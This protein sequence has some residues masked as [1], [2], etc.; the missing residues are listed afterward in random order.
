MAAETAL[1]AT[2]FRLGSELGYLGGIIQAAVISIINVGVAILC[3]LFGAPQINHVHYARKMIGGLS[4]L[5]WITVAVVLNVFAAHYRS[6]LEQD[7]F[8][9]VTAAVDS[10]KESFWGIES[11]QGW[12]LLGVGLFFSVAVLLKVYFSDDPYPGY[13][14]CF[15]AHK[16]ARDDWKIAQ[17]AFADSVKTL[18]GEIERKLAER[19]TEALR[20]FSKFEGSLQSSKTLVHQFKGFQHRASACCQQVV[21]LYRNANMAV[22][23]DAPPDFFGEK[24]ALDF[25]H[26]AIPAELDDEEAE[27]ER[28][29]ILVSNFKEKEV[30]EVREQL[31]E[32][33][34]RELGSLASYFLGTKGWSTK[35]KTEAAVS[36]ADDEQVVTLASR[37]SPQV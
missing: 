14:K 28:M 20:I 6:E 31:N 11:V 5:V 9:A 24:V 17:S 29:K 8:E 23:Q 34:K 7:P 22:R 10:F 35:Q 15:A 3:G 2:F 16:R 12:L 18:H 32:N 36:P 25:A 1:N 13:S 21:G 30:G 27:L 26:L 19:M 37:T 33:T 4:V